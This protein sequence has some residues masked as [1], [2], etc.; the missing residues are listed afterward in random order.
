MALEDLLGGLYQFNMG[1]PLQYFNP[2]AHF[3]QGQ[4][5]NLA[6]LGNTYQ[7]SVGG[8]GQA[9]IGGA[10]SLGNSAMGLYGNLANTQASMYQSELPM[11]MEMQKYNSL[12]PALSG[13]L[14]Q[15]G[16]GF[17]G[18]GLNISPI[19]MNF[20]RP[21]VM[22]GYQGAV[23]NSFGQLGKFADQAY[24]QAKGAF[25]DAQAPVQQIG[26]DFNKQHGDMQNKVFNPPKPPQP[27]Q[28]PNFTPV[29][30]TPVQQPPMGSRPMPFHPQPNPRRNWAAPPN[31]QQMPQGMG[32]FQ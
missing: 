30:F 25:G 15:F 7:N 19:A 3:Q 10:A 29:P 21:D 6:G 5:Q 1:L 27:P 2:Y 4:A 24:G 12:A 9:G 17:G 18:G 32:Y 14:N 23:D 8:I 11:Q 26:K 16:G 20:N 31:N 22:G 13:L 28:N